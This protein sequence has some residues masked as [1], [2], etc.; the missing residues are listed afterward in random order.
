MPFILLALVSD[1]LVLMG[2]A[3]AGGMAVVMAAVLF[4]AF[5]VGW[6]VLYVLALCLVSLFIDTKK[7]VDRPA[8][9]FQW[10]TRYTLKL[11]LAIMRVRVEL[12][13]EELLPEGRWLL[14]SNHR[15]AFDALAVICAFDKHDLAFI[16]KP[17]NMKL[18]LIGPFAHKICCLALD[19]EDD[20][21]ALRS[22]LRAAELVKKGT[23]SFV[24]YPE[25]TR[26]EGEGLLPFRNGAFKI[27]QK[28]KVPIVVMTA[29]N[30]GKVWKNFPFK[31]T[32][33]KLRVLEVISAA[34]VAELNTHD[35]GEEVR[36]C[37]QCASV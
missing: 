6:I 1:V 26:N 17:S 10:A 23:T 22:I 29:E 37:M 24:I 16:S 15:S 35:I 14:V 8:P 5:F 9:F 25:G 20:R 28:A 36:R 7:P 30:T 34:Q 12:E 27:A 31:A 18:P 13:G 21:A 19:R 33:V 4:V 3:F 32:H 11:F 2:G